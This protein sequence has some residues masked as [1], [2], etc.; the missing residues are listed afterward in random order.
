MNEPLLY[1]GETFYQSQYDDGIRS[2]TGVK[3]TT[4][5]VVHNFGWMIPYVALMIVATGLLAQFIITLVR[6]LKRREKNARV[7]ARSTW[8]ARILPIIVPVFA[9]CFLAY[10]A[11]PPKP[12]AKEMDLY[13]FGKLPVVMGGRVQP[14]DTL[15]R[16]SLRLLSLREQYL[17]KSGIQGELKAGAFVIISIDPDSPA[18]F[19]GLKKG[20]RITEIGKKPIKDLDVDQVTE[21]LEG[22]G[23]AGMNGV[24][25]NLSVAI[26]NGLPQAVR[27][28][29]EYRPAVNWL[30]ELITNP[31]QADRLRVFRIE[32]IDVLNMLGLKCREYFRY[33][34][35]EINH[36]KDELDKALKELEDADPATYSVY[37]KKLTE[38]QNRLTFYEVIRGS[39]TES[40]A[41]VS[42]AR[43]SQSRSRNRQA[44]SCRHCRANGK[45]ESTASSGSE[46]ASTAGSTDQRNAGRFRLKRKTSSCRTGRRLGNL[47]PSLA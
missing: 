33:S 37:D 4:L 3:A 17:D 6:F 23:G 5:Q 2:G 14:I 25:V 44:T 21:L 10:A 24:S 28:L 1:G 16:N 22:A 26:G 43:R 35:D 9:A 8:P 32:S 30:L 11:M 12:E 41:A 13:V 47:H 34:W 27:L 40:I 29:R 39:F 38:L 15:A 45:I 7:V 18:A 42:H 19:A 31:E 46:I 36:N 20:D